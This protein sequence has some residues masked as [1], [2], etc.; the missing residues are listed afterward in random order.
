M[1]EKAQ[2]DI[3]SKRTHLQNH[4]PA[5]ELGHLLEPRKTPTLPQVTNRGNQYLDLVTT[6]PRVHDLNLL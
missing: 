5:Q 2:L 4:R 1:Y 3:C 6:W